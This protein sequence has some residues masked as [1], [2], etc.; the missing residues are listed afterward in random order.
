MQNESPLAP[1]MLNVLLDVNTEQ[2]LI[3]AVV[4]LDG[5]RRVP[6]NVVSQNRSTFSSIMITSVLLVERNVTMGNRDFTGRM[7]LHTAVI[8]PSTEAGELTR[9]LIKANAGATRAEDGLGYLPIEIVF[10]SISPVVGM[11]IA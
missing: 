4:V 5:H 6:L 11:V 1:D 10:R 8:N 7:A 3:K 9:R 2:N